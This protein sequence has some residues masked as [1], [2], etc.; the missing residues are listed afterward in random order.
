MKTKYKT[1]KVK[2]EDIA[3]IKSHLAKSVIH[4]PELDAAYHLVKHT[5][6]GNRDLTENR[7]AI[8]IGEAGCGKST[9]MDLYQTEHC[10][11][12]RDDEYKLGSRVD[13]PAILASVPSPVTPKAMSAELL[14]ATGDY[15]GLAQT[16][17][18]LTERLKNNIN[19]SSIEVVFLDEFQ[20]LLSLGNKN[21]INGHTARLRES[22]DWLKSLTN[23]TDVTYVL[24]GM[25]ELL[26]LIHSDP[27]MARR[28]PFTHYLGPFNPPS[29]TDSGLANFADD[30]LLKSSEIEL[31]AHDSTYFTEID[32]FD[33]NP[34]DALRLYAATQGSP[35]KVKQLIIDAACIAYQGNKRKI[36]MT[37]FAKALEKQERASTEAREAAEKRLELRLKQVGKI[38]DGFSNPFTEKLELIRRLIDDL[39]A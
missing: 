39:A 37:H 25:P 29:S 24:T 19:H 4:H 15:T 9:L 11:Q 32:Y 20:H 34:N 8:I 26:Y 1:S 5:I 14:K 30:L 6:E 22:L 2:A 35:S 28:F 21:R 18:R 27:Q 36:G 7:H 16:S 33:E 13:M 12:I 17:H 10:P 31:Q 38:Q 3:A 23:N